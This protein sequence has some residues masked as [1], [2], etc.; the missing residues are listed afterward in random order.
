MKTALSFVLFALIVSSC[1]DI[2]L[3]E[4]IV[5]QQKI[6]IKIYYENARSTRV[7]DGLLLSFQKSYT[8]GDSTKCEVYAKTEQIVAK[9]DLNGNKIWERVNTTNQYLPNSLWEDAAGF[10]WYFNGGSTLT[11]FDKLLNIVSEIKLDFSQFVKTG[12]SYVNRVVMAKSGKIIGLGSTYLGKNNYTPFICEIGE[13]GVEKFQEISKN[14]YT[15][16]TR[17]AFSELSN[18]TWFVVQYT[19]DYTKMTTNLTL[20]YYDKAYQPI[21]SGQVTLKTTSLYD[22][23]FVFRQNKLFLI[24]S[25]DN[26]KKIVSYDADFKRSEAKLVDG[27]VYT[28]FVFVPSTAALFVYDFNKT[29]YKINEQTLD[30]QKY[31]SLNTPLVPPVSAID[32][33]GVAAFVGI[34]SQYV[35]KS[36]I[37]FSKTNP[38]NKLTKQLYESDYSR[39]CNEYLPK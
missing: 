38:T 37:V 6:D 4:K 3:S 39:K 8:N 15:D 29:I 19:P 5:N 12:N 22:D 16:V 31:A 30:N 36:K 18:G 1:D 14:D 32:S 26:Q 23:N 25:E 27:N 17:V 20:S 9:I 13:L 7:S 21:K 10:L 35:A 28:S 2:V 34:E 11:K 33:A 24:V